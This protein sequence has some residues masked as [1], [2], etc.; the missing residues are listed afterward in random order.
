M[1][2][3][4]SDVWNAPITL[5]TSTVLYRLRS[6]SCRD[7]RHRGDQWCTDLHVHIYVFVAS[8]ICMYYVSQCNYKWPES[9]HVTSSCIV[10]Q[11]DTFGKQRL[12]PLRIGKI[13]K[14]AWFRRWNWA[15]FEIW[16]HSSHCSTRCPL[17][18]CHATRG[19]ME[20]SKIS[21]AGQNRPRK[22]T[23]DK[24]KASH[25]DQM[26]KMTPKTCWWS[27]ITLYH[28]E[29]YSYYVYIYLFICLYMYLFIYVFIY[30]QYTQGLH[31]NMCSPP[32]LCFWYLFFW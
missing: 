9:T 12:L 24:I 21:V 13:G 5:Y 3:Y 18:R 6:I 8:A 20:H 26:E 11:L 27:F 28:V 4:F 16:G 31:N 15:L 25:W 29:M 19:H 10:I 7:L 32:P 1:S 30:L 22:L 14:T 2:A 17:A 23:R